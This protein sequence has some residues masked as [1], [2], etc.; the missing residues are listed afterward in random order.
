MTDRF[1]TA[2]ERWPRNG[3]VADMKKPNLKW[4]DWNKL[5]TAEDREMVCKDVDQL[6]KDGKYFTNSPKYQTNINVMGL[7]SSHWMKIKMSFITSCFMYAEKEL[8]IKN[9]QSW[10]YQH[11]WQKQKMNVC[12]L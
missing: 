8:K 7:Q 2:D 9:V 3:E 4:Y 1:P 10:S 5:I 6:I 12:I 11:C